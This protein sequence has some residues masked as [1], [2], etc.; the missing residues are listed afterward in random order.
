VFSLQKLED[1]E[2]KR[3]EHPLGLSEELP[4]K[5]EFV[6]KEFEGIRKLMAEDKLKGE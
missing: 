5:M 2:I 6:D 1:G 3:I 4:K